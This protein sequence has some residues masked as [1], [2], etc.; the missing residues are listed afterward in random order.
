MAVSLLHISAILL[1]M[2][3]AA[4][5]GDADNRALYQFLT[6]NAPI[7][8]QVAAVRK[9]F[10]PQQL[11]DGSA[12]AAFGGDFVFAIE[13]DPAPSL[14]IDD[15]PPVTLRPLPYHLWV[16]TQHLATGTSHAH[17][18][19]VLGEIL[20]GQRFDTAAYG[21]DSYP[22]PGVA[23]GHLSEQRVIVSQVYHG[24]RLSYWIYASP[25]VDPATPAPF[26]VWQDGHRFVY[27]G[28]HARLLTVVENLVHQHKI[29]PMVLLFVAPGYI[30]DFDNSAY[31]PNEDMHRMRSILYDTVSDDYNKLLEE[32]LPEVEKDY[33]LRADGYS[34]GIAGQSSGG[35]CAFNSAW[36]RPQAFS[37]VISRIG[38]FAALQGP[39]SG[40]M[41]PTLVRMRDKRS[42]RVWLEDGSYDHEITAGSWPLQ[43]IEMANSLKL[44]EYDFHFSFGNNQ[45]GMEHGD[46]ELP[47]AMT[48]LWRGY[49]PAKTEDP[50]PMDPSEK[51]KP[52]FRVSIANR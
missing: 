20:G 14:V 52:F 44:R 28:N 8:D 13:S 16:L 21:P 32:I 45:H 15:Q 41:Y 48:W 37:R 47:E 17:Y 34:R 29:P 31:L 4:Q 42:I 19:Y 50:F 33:K 40:N 46:A 43:N 25:G 38:S 30:G 51:K 2:T 27:P 9:H 6:A 3:C 11:R 35:I 1:L 22:Q 39:E 24:W 12:V 23:Q 18:Y 7:P 26:M 10:T 49:D 36:W 5:A